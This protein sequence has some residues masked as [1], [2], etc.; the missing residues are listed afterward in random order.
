MTAIWQ[1]NPKFFPK[2][3]DSD[4]NLDNLFKTLDKG[5]SYKGSYDRFYSSANQIIDSFNQRAFNK[6]ISHAGSLLAL[7][8]DV[9]KRGNISE[10]SRHAEQIKGIQSVM[11][12][13]MNDV[14]YADPNSET[15]KAIN[16]SLELRDRLT[17]A[18]TQY[19]SMIDEINEKN[20]GLDQKDLITQDNNI[21]IDPF[22]DV[23]STEMFADDEFLYS[24]SD[25][26]IAYNSAID[27]SFSSGKSY[28]SD[29][30]TDDQKD[31][32]NTTAQ[33]GNIVNQL[34]VIEK[35][36]PSLSSR[37]NKK[38]L[39]RQLREKFATNIPPRVKASIQL[40]MYKYEVE[41]F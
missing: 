3:N 37:H 24:D 13:F 14:Y 33:V 20:P 15:G 28:V 5:V 19:R 23:S 38:K 27:K 31:I 1:D 39:V 35:S 32:I 17:S 29:Y 41:G 40:L 6:S 10:L 9:L 8:Q 26:S 36:I 21:Y 7:E 2:S 4:F 12:S 25:G 11:K 22:S 30:F 18:F 34:N 16:D